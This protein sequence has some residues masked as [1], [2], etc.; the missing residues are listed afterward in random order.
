MSH[1]GNE[2]RKIKLGK[3]VVLW[4]KKRGNTGGKTFLEPPRSV[5][6]FSRFQSKKGDKKDLWENE[7]FVKLK[8]HVIFFSTTNLPVS[9]SRPWFVVYKLTINVYPRTFRWLVIPRLGIITSFVTTK[10]TCT[11]EMWFRVTPA[12]WILTNTFLLFCLFPCQ[13]TYFAISQTVYGE[14]ILQ[15]ADVERLFYFSGLPYKTVICIHPF[16]KRR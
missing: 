16:A 5:R 12:N 14:G 4:I 13:P 9:R 1:W 11:P 3:G 2:A 6:C 10:F 7:F 8:I 15:I